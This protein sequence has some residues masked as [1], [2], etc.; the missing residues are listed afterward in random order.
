MMPALTFAQLQKRTRYELLSDEQ[1]L[2]MDHVLGITTVR[3][4]ERSR[5]R[6]YPLHRQ[7]REAAMR[8]F[9]DN[10]WDVVPHGIGVWGAKKAMAD[11]AIAKGRKIVLVEC[12]TPSWVYYQ[13]AKNKKRLERFFPLW[14]VLEDPAVSGD[15]NYRHRVERLARKNRVFLWAPGRSLTAASWRMRAK[16]ARLGSSRH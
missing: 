8:Y 5:E 16:V 4:A 11:F 15:I 9:K 6:R 7:L 14:F 3:Q 10:A 1:A 13:N 12:L 2:C